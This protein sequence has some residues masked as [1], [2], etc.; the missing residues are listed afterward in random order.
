MQLSCV[1]HFPKIRTENFSKTLGSVVPTP[2]LILVW[3]HDHRVDS[4]L[5]VNDVC[6]R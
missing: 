6:N 1:D 4:M 5:N 2:L 3:S